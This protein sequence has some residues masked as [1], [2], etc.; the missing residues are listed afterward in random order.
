MSQSLPAESSSSASRWNVQLVQVSVERA[1]T[2]YLPYAVG[3]LQAY[4]AHHAANQQAFDFPPI[5]SQRLPLNQSLE[6]I[7]AADVCG[8][9]CYV[10]SIEYNL[11]L[12]ARLKALRPEVV[13]IFGGP[14]VPDRAEDFL[15]EHAF[16]DVCVHGEGERVFLKLLESLPDKV[17]DEIPGISWLDSDGRFHTRPTAPRIVD[18]DEI[19]SPYVTG[20]FDALMRDRTSHVLAAWETTRGCPFSCA[21]CDWGSN[22]SS[23]VRR[24]SMDYLMAEVEWFST[25][26]VNLV[27]CCDANFGILPR[28]IEIA[29]AVI[30]SF[31]RTGY[32]KCFST[33]SA[34][35]VTDRTYTVQSRISLAGLNRMAT[36]SLQSVSP[37]ALKAIKR[38]NISLETYREM[39]R[40]YQRDGI[41]TYTDLIVG[42]PGESY[43]SFVDG[44]SEIIADGQHHWIWFYNVY[45]LPNAELAQPEY[46]EQHGI[47]SVRIPFSEAHSPVNQIVPEWQEMAIATKTLSRADWRRVRTF[48]WWARIIYFR[49]KLL[50]I[51]LLLLNN[52]A[53]ISY[54]RSFEFFNDGLSQNT[55]MLAG[56]KR[57]LDQKAL[58]L[59]EGRDAAD[60]IMQ[61]PE[62][63]WIHIE[64]FA[65]EMLLSLG[66]ARGFFREAG[67]ALHQLLEQSGAT[68]PPGLLDESLRLS[69]AIS[70]QK[71]LL[72]PLVVEGRYNL[73]EYYQAALRGEPVE[74]R[75]EPC[76]YLR[77]VEEM[78]LFSVR[79]EKTV[80]SGQAGVTKPASAMPGLS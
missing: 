28:D 76:R 65:H 13:I 72:Q 42:L 33:Q 49:S 74:L 40:R 38:D 19:P 15:R 46:R 43:D 8:F 30:E 17:W 23:K 58:N 61:G 64:D 24:H 54:R 79:V 69:E 7:Q 10:W 9:S 55:P 66:T 63:Y 77:D 4:A 68:L 70:V 47:E 36:L 45:V 34:K 75:E 73:W 31:K 57:F 35:N 14:H 78:I 32:P 71:L 53:G 41:E 2:Q 26:S 39:Q 18:L 21:F 25:H 27:Y 37:V 52:L 5:L 12:A 22:I 29:D 6:R 44:V 56:F 20:V 16:I 11:A 62:P 80:N 48:S 1:S 59:Q 50:Q 3:V 60:H 51:P 67:A